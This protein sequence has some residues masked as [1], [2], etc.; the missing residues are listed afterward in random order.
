VAPSYI[1]SFPIVKELRLP[2]GTAHPAGP[3]TAAASARKLV[4]APSLD[5][6]NESCHTTYMSPTAMRRTGLKPVRRVGVKQQV[7]EQLRD[8]IVRGTWPAGSR[9]PSEH[10]LSEK[11]GCS[12]ISIREAIQM[13]ASLGLVQTRQGGGT[14]VRAYS[15]E[16]LMSPLLPMLALEWT[17]LRHVLEYR[18]IMERGCV[19]LAV[20][21]AGEAEI[22]ELEAACEAM[23]KST[24]DLTAFARADLEFHLALARASK[25][26]V[27]VKVNSVIRDILSASMEEIVRA[28]GTRDGL[29]YHRRILAALKARDAAAAEALMEEHV[30]RTIERLKEEF[31]G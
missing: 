12:Y 13:L 26:P 6:A 14:Y 16:V 24:Q 11:L 3:T 1:P 2:P 27:L 5:I 4:A 30:A 31:G 9:L 28:L 23:R 18:R 20:E 22:V 8:G 19:A 7:F 17:D 15:G 29:D 10:E 25:N 21:R